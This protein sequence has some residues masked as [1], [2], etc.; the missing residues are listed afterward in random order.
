MAKSN[1]LSN[2]ISFL[3]DLKHKLNRIILTLWNINTYIISHTELIP[4]KLFYFMSKSLVKPKNLN[5]YYSLFPWSEYFA[6]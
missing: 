1:Y 2:D 5:A 3:N 4:L 6:V